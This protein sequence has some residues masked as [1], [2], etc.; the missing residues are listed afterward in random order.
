MS[1]WPEDRTHIRNGTEN[2]LA[3][4]RLERPP[5]REE[6]KQN[7][8]SGSFSAQEKELSNYQNEKGTP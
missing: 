2:S 3:D 8:P 7:N 5:F 6:E 4:E 1:M